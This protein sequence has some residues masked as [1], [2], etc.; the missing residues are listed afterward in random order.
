MA[1]GYLILHGIGHDR[2]PEHWQFQL[3]AEL[4]RHGHEVRY[5]GLPDSHAPALERWLQALRA[6][7]AALRCE[8]RVVVCHSLACLLWFHAANRGLDGVGLVDRVLLESPPESA[9]VPEAGASHR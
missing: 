4:V 3:A 9:R 2:P 5:P 1:S 7:V 6:E 8:S